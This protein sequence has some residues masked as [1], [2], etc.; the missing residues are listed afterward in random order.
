[1]P[2]SVG[3]VASG[4]RTCPA[5]REVARYRA[6]VRRRAVD[7]RPPGS[8]SNVLEREHVAATFFGIGEQIART[9]RR[10]FERRMFADGDMIGD[11]SW[12]HPDVAGLPV[13]SSASSSS[14]RRR[15]PQATRVHAVPVPAA[16]RGRQP[17]ARIARP[18]DGLRHDQVGRRSA[19]LV[20]AG[21][22]LD[23]STTSSGQRPQR[24]DRDP[25]RRR[26]RSLLKRSPRSR[27]RSTRFAR[28]ATRS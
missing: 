11:H 27:R 21:N 20:A 23:L 25:A 16:V 18:L 1:M 19:G 15:D 8:S 2:R 28:A 9:T 6:H 5:A 10:P 7:T 13:A 26:R 4:H 22:R 17:G 3:C 14:D 24:L 12:S